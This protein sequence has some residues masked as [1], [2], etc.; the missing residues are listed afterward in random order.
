MNTRHT[1]LFA[2]KPVR[3][4]LSAVAA[5]S[6]LMTSMPVHAL[7]WAN[8]TPVA[9]GITGGTVGNVTTINQ[10]EQAGIINWTDFDI[11]AG[12]IANFSQPDAAAVTLN[13]ITSSMD[14]TQIAG[15]INANGGVWVVDP[16]GV[17]IQN[18]ARINVG[19]AF[20]AA[21][22]D[23]S[24]EDF[25]AGN[26]NFD[27]T[28][29]GTGPVQVDSGASIAAGTL[30]ALLG[31]E[32][33]MNGVLTTPQAVLAAAGD[34]IIIDTVNGGTISITLAGDAA[35]DMQLGG[36]FSGDVTA[37]VEGQGIAQDLVGALEIAGTAELTASGAVTLDNAANDFQDGVTAH[38]GL[39][40]KLADTDDIILTDVDTVNG[41]ITV[42]AGGQITATDVAGL[43]DN[44]AND[45]VL[46]GE[47]IAV[48]VISAG[49]GTA[50]DVV[51]DAGTGAITDLQADTVTVG[52]QGF[53]QNAGR[54][55]NVVAD[56]LGMT[57]QGDIGAAG[58]PLDLTVKT[59]AASS[60]NGSVYLYETDMLTVGTVGTVSGVTAGQNA[61]VETINGTLTVGQTVTATAGDLLLAANGAGSDVILNAA[62]GAA[63]DNVTV[64]ASDAFRQNADITAGGT[65]DVRTTGNI[66]M[67]PDTTS[68][69]GGSA[70]D[71][72]RYFSSNGAVTMG[73]LNAGDG[74]VAVD[75]SRGIVSA[76]G[77]VNVTASG[78]QFSSQGGDIGAIPGIGNGPVLT[79]VDVLAAHSYGS[80]NFIQVAAGGDVTVGT[81]GTP[82]DPETAGVDE[83]AFVN[84]VGLDSS[85]TEVYLDAKSDLQSESGD[86]RLATEWG[87]ITVSDGL[88]DAQSSDMD[89]VGVRA[90][91]NILL[92][93]W[94]MNGNVDGDVT[95]N[96]AVVSDAG[97]ISVLAARNI[98]QNVS[99]SA[100]G[101][102]LVVSGDGTIDVEAADG[103]I[104]MADGTLGQTDGGHIRYAASG[105]ITLG[106]LDA[107]TREARDV[108]EDGSDNDADSL[109]DSA[110]P[111]EQNWNRDTDWGLVSVWDDTGSVTDGNGG[112]RNI[113]AR[114]AVFTVPA[115]GIG[116]AEGVG[117][118][119]V[120]LQ[121][122]TLA[123]LSQGN[124]YFIQAPDGR[125]LTIGTVG[126]GGEQINYVMFS[127][128]GVG[129]WDI[130]RMSD[131]ESTAGSVKV[132]VRNGSL[133]VNDGEPMGPRPEMDGVG[134]RAAE[135]VLLDAWSMNGNVDGD[136]TL[137]AAVVSDAGSIS[138]LAARNIAQNVSG[139]AKGDILVVSGDGT[140][141]VEVAGGA[142]VMADGTLG[143]TDGGHIR[144]A[145][146]GGITLGLLDARTREA[147]DVAEDGSDNDADSLVDSADPDEQNWNRDT[148][149][150]LV[151]VWDDTGSVTDGNGG[152]R[153][154]IARGAVFTV[155]AGG[156]GE[157]EGV[158]GGPVDLQVG[159]LAA[160]SQG[161]Q[162]FIQAP[163][164]RD[165]TIGTVGDGGEQINYVMFSPVG[166]GSWDIERMSDLESTAGSVKVGVRNGSLTVND[167][168]PMGPRPEM[169]GVGVR[170]AED[171]LLMTGG[172]ADSDVILN[173]AVAAGDD[174]TLLASGNIE[175]AAAGDVTAAAG[176]VLVEAG[177]GIVMA[178]GATAA[179]GDDLRYEAKGG[180]AKI[181]GL[182]STAADGA[183]M[184]KAAGGITDAGDMARDVEA[185]AA[186]LVAG[187]S[188]GQKSGE[189]NGPLDL[190]V[191]TVA[192][193]GGDAGSV[194]L[195]EADALLVGTVAAV[196]VNRV[197]M[198][199]TSDATA[200][201]A[202]LSGAVAGQNVKIENGV[203]AA[204]GLTVDQAVTAAS[205]D[206][207][208][209]AK[210]GGLSLN[211][212]VT[213]GDDVTLL[214]SRGIIQSGGITAGGTI[215]VETAGGSISLAAVSQ[216]SGGNIRYAAS[217]DVVLDGLLDAG[218]GDVAVEAGGDITDNM[219]MIIVNANGFA[220]P[221]DVVNIVADTV[222]FFAGGNIGDTGAGTSGTRPFN[223][224]TV[225]ANGVAAQ[226]GN[227]AVYGKP[228]LTIA[229]VPAVSVTRL[230]L[231][232]V[233]QTAT[234]PALSGIN[235]GT[236]DVNL[237]A[238]NSVIDGTGAGTDITAGTLTVSAGHIIGAGGGQNTIDPLEV[239]LNGGHGPYD[240]W[241][242][243]VAGS[244]DK[245]VYAF[246]NTVGGKSSPVAAA[247]QDSGALI[248]VN[249]QYV[250][251]DPE[252]VQLFAAVEAFPAET[253]E[254]KSRQG[255][256]GDP[257]FLHDQMDINEPVALGLIDLILTG[258]ATI[259]GAPEIP[260][261]AYRE[262]FSGGLSPSTSFW[263]G[264]GTDDKQEEAETEEKGLEKGEV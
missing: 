213:A 235:A 8:A 236:G 244:P 2:G 115:G 84:R 206:V 61:K 152:A 181:T 50:A 212:A 95:L 251:G 77:A 179:A 56:Q 211:A 112:A 138:V 57:A 136:I 34:S 64:L 199:S 41:A 125:D 224:I 139:S 119:P 239:R 223:P 90:A 126:D 26:M 46:T 35:N 216:T 97:S 31:G 121:V 27:G 25:L 19:A 170:A 160:L 256:F 207:L 243:N 260:A 140:I 48:G 79:D 200:D 134:V 93:A 241:V 169:D 184:V 132:G 100:K 245:V 205:G 149:W 53:A 172:G 1:I 228:N 238:D 104:V 176:D 166:V 59:V 175:Q 198:D 259:T 7:D 237:M 60:A 83:R 63:A 202:A 72:I 4:V 124:Q 85:L 68:A 133:T 222:S 81:V 24:N 80:Q 177:A 66:V 262:I 117:G 190:A 28:V 45:I 158:G 173:A 187:G 153:N 250:G 186:Q 167:G 39:S 254:L 218:A 229:S 154:I 22:M 40:L 70:G 15:Q 197:K 17:F 78:A 82:D 150:G 75:A 105:G 10:A 159:T 226:G 191:G 116:E 9:G 76:G 208:L 94:S 168:E 137:N 263:F 33:S 69:S 114:G 155:P 242:N 219:G 174:V 227:I 201:G 141:D 16:N 163:D 147:R 29:S 47:G 196:D 221:N 178:D 188:V 20:V 225:R 210:G 232:D 252:S 131:L 183:V 130:E 108:A 142:I 107:R 98:A 103:A 23:I 220:I 127:P 214:A 13:R 43:T 37:A 14:G 6:V 118:G 120:D 110:D 54:T 192:A 209:S 194:Y 143:Q 123:A 231:D 113:I 253:P 193:K 55:V 109:V 18:G 51:L 88:A 182:K 12:E 30:A 42:T 52:A 122:G 21:T 165:L 32:V 261:D 157:A 156:I 246:L 215:D 67:A 195:S 102:L 71:N 5:F 111:D 101:D 249:G 264:T 189:G 145:A 135:D 234:S 92:D 217:G 257:F 204:G 148:D 247:T 128:V 74:L 86:I 96:A 38:A 36:T 180:D 248:F 171:V 255:V 89:G 65:I 233:D 73:H 185:S 62:A 162:Y 99:G 106:L 146:S 44:D 164:G 240:I 87:A 58:N 151:S 258:K 203:G 3:R 129:S 144:Y 91:G 49:A 161:N 11:A 230:T